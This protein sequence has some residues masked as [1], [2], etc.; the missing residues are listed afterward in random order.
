MPFREAHHV[1]GETVVEAIRQGKPLEDLSLA[2]LQKFS[3]VIGDDVY[4]ILS[5]QHAWINVRRKA[6]FT[7]AGCAGDRLREGASGVT[8]VVPDD[9]LSGL[10]KIVNRRHP[11]TVIRAW[12]HVGLILFMQKKKR[13]IRSAKVHVGFS[14]FGLR[15]TL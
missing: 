14:Y 7:A 8:G 10:Q 1:V 13:T 6:V 3:A 12:H 2:D 11:A 4:P 5:L 15:K 9:A